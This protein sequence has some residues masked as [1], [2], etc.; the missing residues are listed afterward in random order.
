MDLG[1]KS[2]F[3]FSREVEDNT[4]LCLF[5]L[6]KRESEVDV[7]AM[8]DGTETVLLHGQGAGTLDMEDCPIELNGEVTLQPWEFWIV[9]RG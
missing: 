6:T 4:V 5:N 9:S 2:V 3:A 8:F 1:K 7:S